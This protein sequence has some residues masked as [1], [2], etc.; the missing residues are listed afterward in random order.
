M[1]SGVTVDLKAC[2]VVSPRIAYCV[3]ED[4][5]VLMTED[6]GDTWTPVNLDVSLLLEDIEIIEG[7]GFVV[8]D[9]G[10]AFNF[11][12]TSIS[13]VPSFQTNQNSVNF[14]DVPINTTLTDSFKIVNSGSGTLNIY[15]IFADS[16][17]FLL[18]QDSL[19]IPPGDSSTVYVSFAPSMSG[20]FSGNLLFTHNASCDVDTLPVS[21]TGTNPQAPGNIVGEVLVC[22]ESHPEHDDEDDDDDENDDE[23]EDDDHEGH[24]HDESHTSKLPLSGVTVILQDINGN[25]ISTFTPVETDS[26]G[27]YT[28]SGVFPD[29]Y[30]VAIVEPLGYN[31][32]DNPMLTVMSGSDTDTLDFVLKAMVSENHSRSASYWKQQFNAHIRGHG[33]YKESAS[34]LNA[35]IDAVHLHY[36]PHFDI[37]QNLTTFEDWRSELR[38]R[39]GS[40]QYDRARRELATLVLNF[41]S[42][43]VGQY[44]VVTDDNRTAGDVLTYCSILLTDNDPANDRVA[45]KLAKKVN[46]RRKIAA[47]IIPAGNILYKGMNLQGFNWSFDNA[48]KEFNLYHNFPNP[49]NPSTTIRY[50]LPKDVRVTITVYNLLGQKVAT[51]VNGYQNAGRYQV[52]FDASR[53]ASGLYFYHLRAGQYN[54]VRKMILMK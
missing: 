37:F 1:I 36:S 16:P 3:G 40:S 41:S 45:K 42:L 28:F 11:T 20:V 27:R 25:Q 19:T 17:L 49:F 48:P 30:Q 35:T 43:K 14:G 13:L 22:F 23:D 24:H 10:E 29:S 4:G 21:A 46:K 51:L 44:T 33:K 7:Q 34:E 39:C 15:S 31:V 53:L 9:L 52:Q 54:K 50:D 5:T 47:G 6:C 38:T 26:L 32:N 12:N 8:G 2:K 18:A